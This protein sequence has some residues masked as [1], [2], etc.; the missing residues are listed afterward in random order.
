MR[1]RARPLHIL[2]AAPVAAIVAAALGP[3]AHAQT[4]AQNTP[5]VPV[6]VVIDPGHGG[7]PNNNDP[8]QPFDP[9]AIA[10]SG[11]V[12]KDV[13]LD[14][15]KRVAALLQ[16]DLVD[17]VLTRTTDVGL[18]VS[19][20]E[21]IGIDAHENLFVSIHCNSFPTDPTVGGSL[22]LYPNGQSQAFAQTLEDALSRDLAS[23]G[24]AYDGIVLRDNW[25]IH[26]P[27]PT[28]TVE[29]AYL[30]NPREAALM[31]TED[32]RQQVA[33]AV[34]DGI[35]RYDPQIALRR[36]QILAWE[37]QH[38]GAQPPAP[39]AHH[40]TPTVAPQSSGSAL[41]AVL[42]WLT[43]VAIVASS[44]RWRRPLMRA[45][46]PAFHHV[47][48][49]AARRRR[50]QLRLRRLTVSAERRWAPHSVYDDLSL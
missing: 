21:Q 35:E 42:M 8:T 45:F 6:V 10:P 17:V 38:P 46:A 41:P 36:T 3:T 19:Q 23:S 43:F 29:M 32:F 24:I 12:E 20:R 49:A 40:V 9:G 13:T 27:V 34:R 2:L 18:S 30:S 15:G 5:P 33:I 26:N 4:G 22:V 25:W 44:L 7:S 1:P 11:L 48:R 16:E 47:H 39:R 50:Q 31:A 14:V 37:R 28:G